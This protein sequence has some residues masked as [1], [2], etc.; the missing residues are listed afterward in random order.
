M[1]ILMLNPPFLPKYSTFSRSPAVTKSGTIYYPIWHAYATGVL[2]EE[3]HDVK[4]IDAPADGLDRDACYRIAEEFDPKMVVL[5]TSTGSIYNDVEIGG[6]IKELLPDSLIVLTGPHV[7]ALPR[8]SLE[9]D[10]RIDAIARHE[11]DMTLVE[12]AKRLDNKEDISDVVGLTLRIGGDIRSN[13]DRELISDLDSIPFVS[14]VYKRHLKIE[15]YFYAHCRFPVISIFTSRGCNARCTYCVYPQQMFGRYQRQ[16]SPENIVAEFEYIEKE[17][18]EVKE[19]LIDDDTF[20]FSQEHTIRFCELMIQKDIKLPWT[21]EC[22]ADVKYETMVMMKRAGCRLIV[23][24]FESADNQILKNI[25]KGLTVERMRQFVLDAKKAGIMIHACFMAG[26]KGET[27]DTLMKSLQFAKQ[28]NADTCQFFPLMVYP[29]TEAYE[30]AKTNDYLTTTD[31]RK[32]LTETGLHNCVVSTPELSGKEL[33][34]FCDYARRS[35]YLRP[36]YLAYKMLEVM[37]DP[38][39]LKKT[40]KSARTFMRYLFAR[41]KSD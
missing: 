18:P 28:M 3:G 1:K 10:K 22:R 34:D 4:L 19:V 27:K 7:S 12:I 8:E 23:A 39:E 6:H 11:Y 35:Y 30:W 38:R 26:N 31:F 16:R 21:V 14:S 9:L 5:Y 20:S 29:G 41:S 2:E 36:K 25:K 33:V 40:V 32:W 37:K 24:G 13:P 15:N 17:F